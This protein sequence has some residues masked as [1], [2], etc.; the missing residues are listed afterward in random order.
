MMCH[1]H[2]ITVLRQDLQVLTK[3]ERLPPEF[4]KER[5]LTKVFRL[6]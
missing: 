5:I 2:M 4:Y 3:S 6:S 1:Y